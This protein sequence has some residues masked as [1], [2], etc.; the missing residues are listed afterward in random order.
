MS[1]IS[2]AKRPMTPSEAID[3]LT[4]WGKLT[5]LQSQQP[6]EA[7]YEALPEACRVAVELIHTHERL[8]PVPRIKAALRNLRETQDFLAPLVSQEKS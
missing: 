5:P 8:V 2:D 4:R 3:I 1:T 7:E 6:S